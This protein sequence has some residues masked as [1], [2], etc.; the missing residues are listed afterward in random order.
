MLEINRSVSDT[1]KLCGPGIVSCEKHVEIVAKT[2][3]SII[4]KKHPCQVED[5]DASEDDEVLQESSEDDWYLVDSAMDAVATLAAAIGPQ[6]EPVWKQL[7]KPLL[8]YASSSEHGQRSAAIGTAADVIRG[9]AN[10]VTPHTSVLLKVLLHRMS[11]ED[12][13]TKSN[14]AFAI[15]LL[16]E[17]SDDHRNIKKAYNTIFTK[18]EPLLQNRE[19][20]QLDNAAG[21]VSRM[22]LKHQDSVPIVEVLPALV[23]LLPLKEDFDENEPVYRMIVKLCKFPQAVCLVQAR[24]MMVHRLVWRAHNPWPHAAPPP[25]HRPCHGSS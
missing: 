6:F 16:V 20:R 4:T 18:L 23:G 12:P 22:I 10:A 3:L 8:M 15:G 7:E 9:M 25:C 13:L 19:S 1:L 24:L 17:F 21:C 2:L 11:D 14:A 5:D